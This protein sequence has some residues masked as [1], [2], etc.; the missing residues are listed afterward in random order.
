[1][2]ESSI[3][4][5]PQAIPGAD[6][7]S[8]AKRRLERR[9]Q[10]FWRFAGYVFFLT[11]WQLTSTY[12]VKG[13]ILP[14]PIRIVEKVQEIFSTGLFWDHFSATMTK[15]AIGFSISFVLGSIIGILMGVSRWW[16]AFFSDWVL[17]T[18]TT[19]GLIF[20]L[21]TAMIFGLSSVGPIVAVVVTSYPFVAVNVVEGVRAAP[22]ELLDMARAYDLSAWVRY[23]HVLIPHLAPYF[24]TAIRYGFSVAWKIA[25]LTEI[26]GGT[27]GIGFMMRREFQVFSMSGFL[28]W[29]LLFFAFALFLERA[30]L[31]RQI[32][33]FF[34][35]R[36]E[37]AT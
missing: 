35:W 33:R 19:P 3:T 36:P 1:M 10:W 26:I 18:L 21:V 11:V 4:T 13:F 27:E 28:A 37:V 5:Q 22:Q 30:I 17:M 6:E 31:Q 25:T 9:R 32:T 14:P 24:F 7:K 15:I 8:R 16:E 2:E 20:A 12:L 34:R 23:R 29:A